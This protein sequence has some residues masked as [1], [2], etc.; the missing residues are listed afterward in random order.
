[1]ELIEIEKYI[2]G[3]QE[4]LKKFLNHSTGHSVPEAKAKNWISLGSLRKLGLI[5]SSFTDYI[6]LLIL[7]RFNVN[8]IRRKRFVFTAR[9]FCTNDNGSLHDKIVKPLFTDNIVFINQ[10]KEYR[11]NKINNQRVYNLGGIVIFLQYTQGPEKSRLMRLFKA[12]SLVNDSIIRHLDGTELYM[13]FF[14][15]L[16]SL[17]LIF[18][19][20]RSNVMLIEVQHGSIINYPPYVKPAPI[21]VAEL[22]YV[23][24]QE[25]IDFLKTHL[26]LLFQTNYRLIPYPLIKRALLPGLNL[27]YASTLEFNGLHPVFTEFLRHNP[28]RDL[29]LIIRLHPREKNKQSQ[30]EEELANLNVHYTFDNSQNWLEGNKIAN[31][32]VISPWSSTLEDAYDNGLVSIAIDPTGHNRYSHLLNSDRF[33]YSDNLIETIEIIKALHPH[34]FKV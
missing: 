27:L 33:F 4:D 5:I 19:R 3:L 22:F 11:L 29:N 20:Y 12:Y 7:V 13:L 34:W 16:A 25:T 31:L 23:K 18:S 8:D 1:M 24:N 32:I 10:S 21:K 28:E 9:N 30:F 17:A 14:Y 26:C 6:R 15:D 2:V